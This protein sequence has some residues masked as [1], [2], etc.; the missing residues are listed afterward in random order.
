MIAS[1]A[2]CESSAT[3]SRSGQRVALTR[4]RSSASSASG[5][6][7]FKGRMAVS[8]A[9]ISLSLRVWLAAGS[10]MAGRDRQRSQAVGVE[11]GLGERLR[12]LLR[13]VVPDAAGDGPVLVPA[14]E[15]LPVGTGIRMGRTV[16]VAFQGD[17]GHRD[18]GAAGQTSFQVVV[19]CIT[20]GQAESP[21]VVVD[22]DVDVIGIVEG[23]GALVEGRFV[24]DPLR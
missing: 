6:P 10:E 4:L 21:A 15:L 14:R 8:W 12:S 24:E 18:D 9:G 2:P 20:G 5:K 13:Q 16:R 19:L 11:D 22:D 7:T 1:G 23:A 3:V 17:G